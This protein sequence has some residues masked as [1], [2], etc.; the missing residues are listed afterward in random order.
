ML[1]C[2]HK[3]DADKEGKHNKIQIMS[4][5]TMMNSFLCMV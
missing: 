2:H 5:I 3:N 4:T 1:K